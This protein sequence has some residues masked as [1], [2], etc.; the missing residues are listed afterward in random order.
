M[1]K[2][3][4]TEPDRYILTNDYPS[5][6][7]TK[8]ITAERYISADYMDREQDAVWGKSWLFAGLMSDVREPGDYFVFN[9]ARESIIVSRTQ[10]GEIAAN[11]N[12]C[13]HRGARVL[14]NDMGTLDS[15]VCPYHGWAY[16]PDGTLY[17]VP[18]TDRFSQGAPCE[19]LSLKPVRVDT[20]HGMVWICMDDGGPSLAQFLGPVSDL[21]AP[22]RMQDMTLIE[23]QTVRLECNWK[24]VF[25][26]F[27]ELYHVE[28][29]HPQHAL[30]FD[31]LFCN[32]DLYN[33]GH[34]R[35]VIEGF[36]VNTRQDVPEMPTDIMAPQMVALGM[37][38]ED[39]RGR[40]HDVRA[41]VQKKRREM[42]PSLG[43]NYDLL[44]DDE[45][46]DI[47]QY[48]IFPNSIIVLQPEN[49]LLMRA[50]PHPT[51]PNKCLWDK[52]TFIMEPDPSV[53][54]A[55][56][57]SFNMGQ[58]AS[59]V[60]DERPEHDEFD[61]ED[62]IAGRKTMTITI[63]Q[64]VHFIR[65]VQNGMHSKGFGEAWLNDDECRIQHYHDWLNHYM[66]D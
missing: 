50:M 8:P 23:D 48:N 6:A 65:D 44:S 49:L 2:P 54:G 9:V 29:I 56:N 36:T 13:Q 10:D 16:H 52:F 35:V 64:D 32:T 43:H 66:G 3:A 45:L 26:N 61:Q 4:T 15:F 24:A 14:V 58:D 22:F 33:Q 57:V 18:D 38:P 11:Y 20:L 42:G 46:S 27:H 17:H 63:D 47:V 41:A 30:I 59:M 39:F 1:S 25:D 34:S 7:G 62:I 21:V 31:C 12:V 53:A 51:D 40:V 55:A 19:Q 5:P 28:H 60:P 37:D